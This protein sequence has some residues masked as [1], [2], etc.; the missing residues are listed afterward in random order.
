[1]SKPNNLMKRDGTYYA[2]VYIPQDLQPAFDGKREKWQS[3]RTKDLREAKARLAVV[4]DEWSARF[5]SMR[6]GVSLSDDAVSRAIY[7]HYETTLARGDFE[8]IEPTEDEI[9]AAHAA[10]IVE[11]E[12]MQKRLGVGPHDYTNSMLDVYMLTNKTQMARDY[13]RRRMARLKLDLGTGD[14]R[15][16]SVLAD[17]LIR[18]NNFL[19]LKGSPE[20]RTLCEGL[21]RAELEALSHTSERET[22]DFTG[23]IKDPVVVKPAAVPAAAPEPSE[24]I[25]VL[26]AKYEK[27]NPRAMQADSMKQCRRDVEHFVAFAGS[28]VKAS[29]IDRPMVAAWLDLLYDYPVKA[30]ET[31]V[32][33]G[34]TPQEIIEANEELDPPKPTLSVN[35]IRRYLSSLSG[36]CHW[37][38]VRSV[39][40]DNPI[41]GM[42]PEKDRTKKRM[43][44][45]G[46]QMK[47]LLESP[48][49]TGCLGESWQEMAQ[50]GTHQIR[51]H[52]YWVPMIMAYSGARPG[53]IAQLQT[54]DV[55]QH[56]GVWIMHITEMGEGN[57]RTKTEGSMRVVP[58]HSELIRLGFVRHCEG[59][60]AQGKKQVFPEVV[61]P[62][63]GQIIPEFS[64]EMNRTYLPRIGLKVDRSLSV[65]SL[66]HTVVDRLRLAGVGDDE[67]AFIVG[68]EK[69]TMTGRYGV[70]QAGTLQR[71]AEII[72]GIKYLK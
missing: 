14:I 69:A 42:F 71:R 4:L 8:R 30:T 70:E 19:T 68:H 18:E 66:R 65:Y 12:A 6:Q 7:S 5:T 27:A 59:M 49:F 67:I 57:K 31:K 37:L 33:K 13:R 11:R 40:R 61:I 41:L 16:I 45:S 20:Y 23:K 26:F 24:T 44:F 9:W 43:P 46:D 22:G 50:S 51:D 52:R 29:K 28:S 25:M 53:E 36:F 21:I 47:T 58:L 35:T 2:R 34:M 62:K 55:R 39:L 38:M 63:S 10:S 56:H 15:L 3:L 64:R 1:V 32:F 72:E 54:A 48:L 60:V 17:K